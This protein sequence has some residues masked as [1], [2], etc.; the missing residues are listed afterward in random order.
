MLA[1]ANL[2]VTSSSVAAFMAIAA[3]AGAASHEAAR[4]AAVQ[5]QRAPPRFPSFEPLP[6]RHFAHREARQ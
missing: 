3:L 6:R 4:R 1:L 5:R 2:I